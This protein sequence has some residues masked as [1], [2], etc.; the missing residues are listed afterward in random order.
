MKTR[1]IPLF[2][3]V[4]LLAAAAVPA[5]AAATPPVVVIHSDGTVEARIA[6]TAAPGLNSYPAPAPP[7][8]ATVA[9]TL[10]G[11]TV[12]VVYE[13]NT[14]YIAASKAGAVAITYL[15]NTTPVDG[16]LE[17]KL[18][19]GKV[20]LVVQPGVVLLTLPQK[21]LSVKQVGQSLELLVQ[22]PALVKYTVAKPAAPAKTA[23]TTTTIT[24][25]TTT[26]TPAKT[27][28]TTAAAT[29]TATKTATATTTVTQTS[30]PT[31][32]KTATSTKTATAL[33]TATATGTATATAT[34]PAKTS[35]ATARQSSGFSPLL[36]AAIILI[37]A[38]VIVLIAAL[39]RGGGAQGNP[40]RGGGGQGPG[41][42]PGAPDLRE[43]GLDEV[44]ELILRKLR[45]HGG[46]MLQS[47]L[48]RET[49]LPKTTLW[50]HVNKLE[51]LGY[52]KV[53]REGKS[54]RLVIS[55]NKGKKGS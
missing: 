12:P 28:T 25:T 17:F 11:Q 36:A 13:N 45:E 18:Y 24:T 33:P 54:N 55:E 4:A 42:A 34:V 9:A 6:G 53:I 49:G 48:Q 15:V 41:E 22:G 27:A 43:P 1:L 16:A 26:T 10:D 47:Q 21:I 20:L 31:A 46:T 7:I 40:S 44:D 35:T 52:I 37:A 8:V 50:R 30:S 2:M 5:A 51:K 3:L 38:A 29:A 14:F 19:G 32:T 23:E 39:K